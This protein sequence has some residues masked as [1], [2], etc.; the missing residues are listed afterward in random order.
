MKHF[1]GLC[2]NISSP[3]GDRNVRL[4]GLQ[5]PGLLS[6]FTIF[7]REI[8]FERAREIAEENREKYLLDD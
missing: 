7:H 3:L 1:Q 4:V 5:V 6:L 8:L 2:E